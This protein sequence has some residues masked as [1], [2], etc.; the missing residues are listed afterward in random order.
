MFGIPNRYR[1]QILFDFSKFQTMGSRGGEGEGGLNSRNIFISNAGNN[2]ET[3]CRN[4]R[5]ENY[6]TFSK[7]K[8]PKQTANQYSNLRH[9]TF[10]A[11]V[12]CISLSVDLTY[13]L[14]SA[15]SL[16]KLLLYIFAFISSRLDLIGKV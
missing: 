10:N 1:K 2:F 15:V 8:P 5:I 4:F 6:F 9:I 3:T 13:L 7:R 12:F 16:C 14:Q 11:D